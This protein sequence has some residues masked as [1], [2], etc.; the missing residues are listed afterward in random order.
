MC[1]VLSRVPNGSI[2]DADVPSWRPS[3]F[4]SLRPSIL[5]E[6]GPPQ[7][8]CLTHGCPLT[9]TALQLGQILG[10]TVSC[11]HVRC[12]GAI[13]ISLTRNHWMTYTRNARN[14]A[15]HTLHCLFRPLFGLSIVCM[16]PSGKS[17]TVRTV[18]LLY[19]LVH[20]N[21][22]HEEASIRVLVRPSERWIARRL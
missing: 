3:R 12:R 8:L 17:S 9:L 6:A 21:Y 13:Y 14:A 11:P 5:Y 19:S 7:R 4:C 22:T 20:I 10:P 16:K 18:I 2:D 1:N 15:P